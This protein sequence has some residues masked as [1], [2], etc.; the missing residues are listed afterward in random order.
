MSRTDWLVERVQGRRTLHLGCTDWPYT[1]DRLH[2]ETLLHDRLAGATAD[3][4]GLDAS[5]DGLALLTAAGYERLVRADADD[6]A[7]VAL[8]E[9]FDVVVAGELIEHLDDPGR[10]LA[11]VPR[12]LRPGGT[13]LI[14]TVNAYCGFRFVQYALRGRGGTVE[15]VHPDHVA[16]YSPSTIR[17]LLGRHG[18]Q[19]D[20]WGF[21]DLGPE[22]RPHLRRS[23]GLVNDLCVRL[24]PQLADGLV[25]ACRPRA[26]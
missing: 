2:T 11:G 5:A 20:D 13:L 6:P 16:Y 3:L 21:Y 8:D 15:P 24:A 9:T 26:R 22:H 10:F 12:F 1:A 4:W 18:Y 19:V 7:S 23:L 14:T 25:F 17:V